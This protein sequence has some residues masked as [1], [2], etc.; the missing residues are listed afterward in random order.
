LPYW[1]KGLL[2]GP[3]EIKK[4]GKLLAHVDE[5]QCHLAADT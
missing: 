1:A 3:I 4:I 2:H 5:R